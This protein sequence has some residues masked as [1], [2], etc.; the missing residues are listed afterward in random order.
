MSLSSS[1]TSKTYPLLPKTDEKHIRLFIIRHGETSYNQQKIIQGH[2]NISLNEQGIAQSRQLNKFLLLKNGDEFLSKKNIEAIYS[3]DL[4]RCSETSKYALE[5]TDRSNDIIFTDQLRERYMG[6]IQGLKRDAAVKK[7]ISEGKKSINDF[8]ESVAHLQE[9]LKKYLIDTIIADNKD[10]KN[11]MI[12]SHGAA[13]RYLLLK[14]FD[15]DVDYLFS[16]LPEEQKKNVTSAY[17]TDSTVHF[18]NTCVNIVDFDKET[19]EFE[20]KLLN[21]IYHITDNSIKLDETSNGTIV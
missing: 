3:S 16:K 5:G 14:L 17:S 7:A 2:L 1:N 6:E 9:R 10:K 4:S 19:G 11:L 20:L 18:G 15:N 8:G 21:G 12:F 13:I